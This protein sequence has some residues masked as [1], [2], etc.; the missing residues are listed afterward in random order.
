MVTGAKGKPSHVGQL[1][2]RHHDG[3]TQIGP[4][5]GF[6]KPDL[7]Q[8]DFRREGLGFEE[9]VEHT[10]QSSVGGDGEDARLAFPQ[11]FLCRNTSY[12][13]DH[14]L[15]HRFDPNCL[16]HKC[17]M[18]VVRPGSRQMTFRGRWYADSCKEMPP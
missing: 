1:S 15:S 2:I 14:K 6:I 13:R 5:A 16:I 9:V 11:H 10:P 3:S 4:W 17:P 8:G 12:A 18:F 7:R